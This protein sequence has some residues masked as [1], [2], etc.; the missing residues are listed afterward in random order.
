[1]FTAMTATMKMA[2]GSRACMAGA[3]SNGLRPL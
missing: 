2:I 3:L 1:M